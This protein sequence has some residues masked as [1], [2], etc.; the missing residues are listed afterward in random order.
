MIHLITAVAVAATAHANIIFLRRRA[1]R[2]GHNNQSHGSSFVV[3]TI[4]AIGQQ[5]VEEA[6]TTYHHNRVDPSL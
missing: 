2:M 6:Q 5:F 1:G 3:K 4:P